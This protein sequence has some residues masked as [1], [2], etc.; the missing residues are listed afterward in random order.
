MPRTFFKNLVSIDWLSLTLRA[1]SMNFQAIPSE[2]FLWSERSYG[3]KQYRRVFDIEYVDEDA[4]C[5]PFAC[6]CCEP[7]LDSWDKTLCSIK[8]ANNLFYTNCG[9]LWQDLLSIFLNTYKLEVIGITRCD[10]ACDFL[11]LLNRVSGPQL[12]SNLKSFRWWK[13]GSVK[14]SEHYTLPYSIEW[15]ATHYD[16]GSST[17]IYLQQGKMQSRVESMTFGT[18]SSDAQVIIYDKTLELNRNMV[19]MNVGGDEIKVSAKEYIRDAHKAAGVFDEQRHTWRIEIRLKSKSCFLID[20]LNAQAR[21]VQLADLTPEKLPY[22]FRAAADRYFRLVDATQGGT[23]EITPDYCQ[24]MAS[25]KNR[26]P[27]I[28]L[29]R[30]KTLWVKL[31]KKK[32]QKNPSRFTKSVINSLDAHAEEIDQQS[33][34]P[35]GKHLMP[36]DANVLREAATILRTIY[37]GQYMDAKNN[38]SDVFESKFMQLVAAFNQGYYMPRNAVNMMFIY[39]FSNRYVSLNFIKQ[40]YHQD[41]MSNFAQWIRCCCDIDLYYKLMNIPCSDDRWVKPHISPEYQRAQSNIITFILS[42]L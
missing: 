26:L 8:L 39:I 12:V 21:P 20:S 1:F 33:P 42:P 24:A 2:G 9:Q 7:T 19:S 14:V 23:R 15:N 16:D 5:Q 28:D 13:C 35:S 29:F 17:E 6:F 4:V 22:V 11:F 34:N 32:Y 18:M 3:T 41:E 27:I 36:T 31:S 38:R 40:I 37:V 30:E 10:L 25:H